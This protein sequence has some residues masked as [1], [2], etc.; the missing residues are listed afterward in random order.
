MLVLSSGFASLLQ[1][2]APLFRSRVWSSAQVL[3]LGAILAPGERTVTSVLRIVG[4]GKERHF[5]NYHRVLNRARWS[6]R[7]ASRILL[8]TRS[9][10]RPLGP[11]SGGTG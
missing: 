7:E 9:N 1:A 4:L 8:D 2:F 3:L 6:S 10:I 5:Q 11:D